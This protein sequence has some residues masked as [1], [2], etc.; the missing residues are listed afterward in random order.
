M[1]LYSVYVH[2]RRSTVTNTADVKVSLLKL[3]IYKYSV[4]YTNRTKH[5]FKALSRVVPRG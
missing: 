1:T 4:E 3:T 5:T 2:T